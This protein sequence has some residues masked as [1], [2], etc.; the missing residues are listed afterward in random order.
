[1]EPS[2]SVVTPPEVESTSIPEPGAGA[3][4]AARRLTEAVTESPAPRSPT[5][6]AETAFAGSS[7]PRGARLS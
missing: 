3:S 7:D 2:P 4:R 1:M 5:A 6:P